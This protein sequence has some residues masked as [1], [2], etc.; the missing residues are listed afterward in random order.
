MFPQNRFFVSCV[1]EEK[2]VRMKEEN[3]RD[4]AERCLVTI[5]G[6]REKILKVNDKQILDFFM[7]MDDIMNPVE[8]NFLGQSY[9]E[10]M[11]E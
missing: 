7:I 3:K 9:D 5:L 6:G 4:Y 8:N 10:W 1:K 2:E 11:E